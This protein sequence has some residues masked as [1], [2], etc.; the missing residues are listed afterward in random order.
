MGNL[1]AVIKTVGFVSESFADDELE[2]LG[3]LAVS[4]R[5]L[6]EVIDDS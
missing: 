3:S 2:G 5:R 6:Q 4:R 1:D